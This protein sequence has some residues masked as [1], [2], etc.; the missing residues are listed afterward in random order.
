MAISSANV[1]GPLDQVSL[2]DGRPVSFAVA[3][4]GDPAELTVAAHDD[5]GNLVGLAACGLKDHSA[6]Q[7]MSLCVGA[8]WRGQGLGA[9]LVRR[10]AAEASERG[11]V[12]LVL[13][14]PQREVGTERALGRSGLV[15]SR[16]RANHMVTTLVV[17]QPGDLPALVT[18]AVAAAA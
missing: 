13:V 4:H 17:T 18:P 2:D 11:I 8:G 16:K 10:L 12:F 7:P 15:V 1:A 9:A 3:G 5:A 6:R 14:H